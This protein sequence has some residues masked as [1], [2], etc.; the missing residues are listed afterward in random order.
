MQRGNVVCML[1]YKT[2]VNWSSDGYKMF[3]HVNVEAMQT[4]KLTM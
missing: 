2:I 4:G 3:R 1:A